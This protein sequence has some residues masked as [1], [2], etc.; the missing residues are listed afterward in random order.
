LLSLFYFISQLLKFK[1]LGVGQLS[2]F[3]GNLIN[4]YMFTSATMILYESNNFTPIRYIFFYI[5]TLVINMQLITEHIYT[6]QGL[7]I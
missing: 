5:H 3:Y 1:H 6:Q 7:Y 4:A 2:R